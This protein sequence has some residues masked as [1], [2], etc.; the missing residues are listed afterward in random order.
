MTRRKEDIRK[1]AVKESVLRVTN[2]RVDLL[3]HALSQVVKEARRKDGSLYAIM[4]IAEAALSGNRSV[5]A[6]KHPVV[7]HNPNRAIQPYVS[8][9]EWLEQN[10]NAYAPKAR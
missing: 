5:A 3:V 4:G 6:V 10:P 9:Q 2:A 8:G 7:P 1:A